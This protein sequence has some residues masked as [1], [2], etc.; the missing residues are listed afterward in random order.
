MAVGVEGHGALEIRL[1]RGEFPVEIGMGGARSDRLSAFDALL[2][3]IIE[4]LGSNCRQLQ[5]LAGHC[6]NEATGA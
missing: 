5:V 3:Y 6:G 4:L 2:N 1:C